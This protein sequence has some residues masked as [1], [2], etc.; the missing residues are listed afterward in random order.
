MLVSELVISA[1]VLDATCAG[2][3]PNAIQMVGIGIVLFRM[4]VAG[5]GVIDQ[6]CTDGN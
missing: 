1:P 5:K 3:S 2:I 4:L 6:A